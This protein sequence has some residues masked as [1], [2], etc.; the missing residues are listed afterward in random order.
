[1][2]VSSWP[3][4]VRLAAYNEAIG[5]C[6]ESP[7]THYTIWEP[8]P[9]GNVI[10]WLTHAIHGLP[11]VSSRDSGELLG[12]QPQLILHALPL[13]WLSFWRG[14]RASKAGQAEECATYVPNFPA[15]AKVGLVSVVNH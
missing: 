9:Q 3:S 6:E 7:N 11:S 4:C 14:Q 10:R 13:P 8:S 1:M 2:E 15:W 12:P 5:N